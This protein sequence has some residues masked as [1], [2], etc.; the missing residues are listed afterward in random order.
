MF[1][2]FEKKSIKHCAKRR[3][4]GRVVK[5][6]TKEGAKLIEGDGSAWDTTCN[7]SIRDL[8]EN[9]V[10]KHIMQV[11]IPYGVVPEQW[12]AE[13]QKCNEK[14]ELKLFFQR[15]LDKMRIRIDAIR[16]SGHRGT[17]CLN[18]WMNFVNWA[19]SIY[20]EPERFLDPKVRKGEDVMGVKR[21]WAGAFEGDDSLC[22][23]YPPMMEGDLLD[24][25]FLGWWER[26]GFRMKI[27]YADR[28]ATFCGYHIAC[29]YGEPTGFACPELVRALVGAGITT[30]STA[31]TAAKAG[32]VDTVR[33]S[34][35]LEPLLALQ[36]LQGY[37][38]QCHANFS[39]T[40]RT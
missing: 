19:C 37:C 8:V 27:I 17:S 10:L 6:L 35:L 40:R 38:R 29:A 13:H 39:D 31:I 23:L 28:R 12:H 30:S 14:K 32:D 33:A 34:Q 2:W 21:W 1:E 20:K 24:K 3:A 4:I 26:Q 7:A 18:W 16:R 5:E 25:N 11:L 22:A 15:K 9:P 36:I